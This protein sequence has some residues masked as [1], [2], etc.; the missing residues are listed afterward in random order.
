MSQD[1]LWAA[2]ETQVQDQQASLQARQ[3]LGDYATAELQQVGAEGCQPAA[4]ASGVCSTYCICMVSMLWPACSIQEPLCCGQVHVHPLSQYPRP[5]SHHH[6]TTQHH[7]TAQHHT[8][9]PP[10]PSGP[11]HP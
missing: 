3:Q 8:S 6:T 1:E 7:N 10:L 5:S 4:Q 11:P 2:L 9:Q